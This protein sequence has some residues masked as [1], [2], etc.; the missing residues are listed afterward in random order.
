[1][2][3]P[4][5]FALAALLA[6]AASCTPAPKPSPSTSP[7]PSPAAT[8]SHAPLKALLVVAPDED[9]SKTLLLVDEGG[10]VVRT[11]SLGKESVA[12]EGARLSP[13]HTHVAY[14]S[15]DGVQV[16]DVE[17]GV[18]NSIFGAG[19]PAWSPDG[20]ALAYLDAEGAHLRSLG[21][22]P[23][24]LMKIKNKGPVAPSVSWVPDGSG[25]LIGDGKTIWRVGTAGGKPRALVA[26]DSAGV[27]SDGLLLVISAGEQG[28]FVSDARG[29]GK[30][31]ISTN[32]LVG[33][34]P[35]GHSAL[36]ERL[37]EAASDAADVSP[38][39]RYDLSVV[40]LDT[41]KETLVMSAVTGEILAI[42]PDG[43]RA[44]FE[45]ILAARGG[46][47]GPTESAI[48]EIHSKKVTVFSPGGLVVDWR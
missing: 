47:V 31:R 5:T 38:A 15:D 11:V 17:S 44:I 46:T 4:R 43:S 23:Q 37:T 8:Q 9:V 13:D 33:V 29:K 36:V 41:G 12:P 20:R 42:S 35:G 21:G 22:E 1:M 16:L 10:A 27:T 19:S 39:D 14:E 24:L 7:T 25:I 2:R 30:R 3:G 34:L 48:I 28:V 32:S 6:A 26:G 40:D 45:G 18:E